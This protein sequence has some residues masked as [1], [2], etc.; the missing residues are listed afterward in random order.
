MILQ[1]QRSFVTIAKITTLFLDSVHACISGSLF[2][3]YSY[4]Y[5]LCHLV[6]NKWLER[7]RTQQPHNIQY[8]YL[9]AL[10]FVSRGYIDTLLDGYVLESGC[11]CVQ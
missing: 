6:K 1:F 2:L 11:E 9:I 8:Q 7:G 10:H 5:K 3:L 4:G